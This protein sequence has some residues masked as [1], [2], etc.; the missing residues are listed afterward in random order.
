MDD[1]SRALSELDEVERNVLTLYFDSD[2]IKSYTPKEIAN[3]L[4]ITTKEVTSIK[5]KALKKIRNNPIM[6]K[7][8]NNYIE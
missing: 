1:Y 4:G 8:E 3:E 6:K 5:T 7:Y 2:G